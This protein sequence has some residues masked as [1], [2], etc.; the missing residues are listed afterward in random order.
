MSSLLQ[1][2][3]KSL[4]RNPSCAWCV[5][6]PSYISA[7]TM[8]TNSNDT[9]C[10]KWHIRRCRKQWG[11]ARS[12]RLPQSLRVLSDEYH[13]WSDSVSVQCTQRL[14]ALISEKLYHVRVF[15][16]S[17]RIS[18]SSY[19]FAAWTR[20]PV[21]FIIRPTMD[22]SSFTASLRQDIVWTKEVW[23]W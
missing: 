12:T 16:P 2:N 9:G 14:R 17:C 10:S 11:F 21:R 3:Y 20:I 13:L 7:Q 15:H 22:I 5:W 19:S 1:A 8:L 6:S 4:A 18:T 23:W